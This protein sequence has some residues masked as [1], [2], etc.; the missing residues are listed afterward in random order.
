MSDKIVPD[1]V[2]LAAK[3]GFIRT[4]SQAY[5]TALAGGITSTA[6]LA[7]VTG[8]VPLV[9]VLVTLGVALVSPLLAGAASYL[10]ILHAGIPAEY[11]PSIEW[12]EVEQ[13]DY[14]H[15]A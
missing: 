7:V 12:A 13:I 5:A 9:A 1:D 11:A 10:S 15:D 6:V 8:E 3:R 2:T 4:T 14:D